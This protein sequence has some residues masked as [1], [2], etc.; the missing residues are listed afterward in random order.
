MKYSISHIFTSAT[1]QL[2]LKKVSLKKR[3]QKMGGEYS[4][5]AYK[6]ITLNMHET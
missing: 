6:A 3:K 4:H 1:V 5:P 2:W